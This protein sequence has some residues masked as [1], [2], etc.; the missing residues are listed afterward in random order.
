MHKKL[1]ILIALFVT[2]TSCS[3]DFLEKTPESFISSTTFYKTQSDF[4]QA[5]NGI[6]APLRDL[7]GVSVVSS[8]DNPGTANWMMGEMRSDNTIYIINTGNRGFEPQE[9]IDNFLD[10]PTNA[11]SNYKYFN[12]YILIGRANLVL[13]QIDAVAFDE[14]AK[15]NLKGQAYFLRALAYFDLV[16]YF[17]D[18]PLH[19]TPVT[20]LSETALP[21]SIKDAVYQQIIADA[22][23]AA[24]LL[25]L[26]GVQEKGRA[27]SGA[28]K[29]LLGNVH[30]VLK[31]WAEAETVLKEVLNSNEYSLVPGYGDIY[32]TSN[33]NNSESVFEVQFQE[34]ATQG[35]YSTFIYNFLPRLPDPSIITGVAGPA[36]ANGGWNTPTP[37]LIN[38]YEAGDRRKDASI[39]TAGGYPYIKKYQ[40][41][42]ANYNNTNDNWPVYRFA[43]VLLLLSESL[44]EQN[45]ATEALPHLNKVR[46]RAFGTGVSLVTNTNQAALRDIIMHE[47]QIEFA[48]ENK[49][50]LDL[51]RTGKAIEIMSAQGARIKANPQAYYFPLTYAPPPASYNVQAY[52]LL[53]PLP[54]RERQLNPDLTQNTGY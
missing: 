9:F 50:W 36:N 13:A 40:N 1:I 10:D 42:H 19:L 30:I 26:K 48:F 35:L 23:L 24:S 52:R 43:E 54:F 22:K 3:K 21:R 25:P 41:P 17:G 34:G 8:G 12:N 14:T 18:V 33:K 44:N 20:A 47:R 51:V 45:K 28:A 46:D 31:Q 27:T 49:R 32:K 15:K 11:V 29:T 53:F 2:F 38:S 6:Y 4:Q 37:D 5:V 16:Q 7:Y 39:G